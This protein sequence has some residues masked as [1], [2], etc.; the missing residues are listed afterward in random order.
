MDVHRAGVTV[1]AVAPDLLQQPLAGERQTPVD[2]QVVQQLELLGRQVHRRAVHPHGPLGGQQFDAAQHL[3]RAAGVLL[4]ARPPLHRPG[5]GHQLPGTER[6]DHVVV[7][8]QLQTQDLVLL[9]VLGGEDDERR[10]GE[11]PDRLE[12]VEARAVGQHE[13][14]H[15]QRRVVLS[16]QLHAGGAQRG[17]VHLI[18]LP[19]QVELEQL[20]DRGI[21]LDHHHAAPVRLLSCRRD[22]CPPRRRQLG[23]GPIVS[24][25]AR[26][27][28][29]RAPCRLRRR[30]LGSPALQRLRRRR[31]QVLVGER[32]A[33]P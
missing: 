16:D 22:S 13:V 20:G 17:G 4:G 33:A 23:R 14:E 9:G 5:P 24:A 27:L 32:R 12:D 2:Q 15:H 1:G 21:V 28:R 18:A 30:V 7:G 25:P 6:L 19:A 31:V 29:P 3:R 10:L 11:G 8:P 26:A